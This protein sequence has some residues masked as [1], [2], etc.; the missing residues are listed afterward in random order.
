MIPLMFMGDE[1]AAEEPFLFFTSHHGELA[2]LVRE[3]RRNEFAAFSA[4][5]DPH[6]RERIPDPNARQTFE[7]SRPKLTATRQSAMQGLYR[8]LLRLRHTHI[9]P[10]LPGTFA[11]GAEVLAEGAVTARWQLSN[12]SQ[13]RIDLNLSDKPVVHS[14]QVDAS[15]LFEHPPQ[16][17]GLLDQGTLAPYC[18]LVSLTAAAPMLPPDGERQ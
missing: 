15:L 18:A 9:I 13:L 10:N 8:Q 2:E 6:K 17:A 16:S 12:G 14:P 3:G 11:L 1:F 7:A 5:T 4:F